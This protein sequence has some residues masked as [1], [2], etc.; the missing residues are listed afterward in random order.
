MVSLAINDYGEP[1]NALDN[2]L[3]VV[4]FWLS[5]AK[6]YQINTVKVLTLITPHDHYKYNLINIT[7]HG[8]SSLKNGSEAK[9]IIRII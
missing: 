6:M 8:D 3:V 5:L 4:V 7:I 1:G 9:Y 2:V